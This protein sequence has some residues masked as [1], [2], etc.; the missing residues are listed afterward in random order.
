MEKKTYKAF[1]NA[2]KI[3]IVGNAFNTYRAR[4]LISFLLSSPNYSI[5][6]S[7]QRYL[8][9]QS[10][11]YLARIFWKGV[12]IIDV[13]MNLYK[14]AD[15]DAVY[16]LPMASPNIIEILFAK[17]LGKQIISE[18]YISK[19]DT[20]INDRQRI[21]S[22][23][24]KAIVPLWEDKILARASSVLIFLNKSEANYYLKVIDE[25]QHLTKSMFIPL[26]AKKKPRAQCPYLNDQRSIPTLCWWGTYIPLHG[27]EK[28]IHAAAH[29]RERKMP[30]KM[31][32]FGN[33][34]ERAKPFNDLI[35]S[36][37]LEDS[38]IIDNTK[39]FSDDSLTD[40]LIENCDLAF[41]NFG[42]SQ[43][44]KTVMVNKVVEASS[45]G[46]PVVSQKTEA[47]QEY[48]SSDAIAYCKPNPDEIADR[49]IDLLS[50]K[51]KAKLMGQ[52]GMAIYSAKFSKSTYLNKVLPVIQGADGSGVRG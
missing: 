26:T 47:L 4:V 20:L 37:K 5:Y 50:D 16:L 17:L 13:L 24:L 51:R 41:G 10:N 9:A 7:D 45:M 32:L 49:I 23:S 46:L 8:T 11:S 2:K 6:Y 38:V 27:L 28:I 36:L 43:K 39:H 3:Y 21:N 14:I 25:Q 33:S 15:A 44:A 19:F 35:K 30:V 34:E 42:D 1:A 18:F 12:K 52:K 40:F 31:H 29:L 48:F 22:T